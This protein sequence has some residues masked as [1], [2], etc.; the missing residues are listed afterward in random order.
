MCLTALL[1]GTQR[2]GTLELHLM[3][4]TQAAL[5]RPCCLPQVLLLYCTHPWW[6]T[7]LAT[8]PDLDGRL[9]KRQLRQPGLAD[10][11]AIA[12]ALSCNLSDCS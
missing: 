11:G 2:W 5:A 4:C 3:G 9:P 6:L 7:R 10:T 8:G 12:E 1:D